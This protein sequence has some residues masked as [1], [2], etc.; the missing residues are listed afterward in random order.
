MNYQLTLD[1]RL[2]ALATVG[3]QYI[4]LSLEAAMKRPATVTAH[5]APTVPAAPAPTD[6]AAET[7]SSPRPSASTRTEAYDKLLA[8]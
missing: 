1:P 7:P 4:G 8:M 5:H 6:R 2:L 3:A